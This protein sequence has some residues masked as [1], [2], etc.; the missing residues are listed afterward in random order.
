MAK[1]YVFPGQGSQ[2]AGMGGGLFKEFPQQTAAASAILGYAIEELCGPD[3][4]QELN[5]TEFTQPAL[6]VVNALSYLR[7]THSTSAPPNFVAG[8][9]LGEYNALFAAGVFDFNTGVRLVQKR[10][11]LMSRA[12][13]GAMAAVLGMTAPEVEKT[14]RD[15]GLEEIDIANLNAPQ[16]VVISGPVDRVLAAGTMFERAG[17]RMF[18]P[19][20]VSGSFHS[21]YMAAAQEEFEKYLSGF[22]FAPPQIPVISNVHARPYESDEVRQNLAHQITRPVRWVET[23][24]FLL[25]Q[26]NPEFEEIGPGT[27]LAGLI[28][29]IKARHAPGAAPS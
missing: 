24:E 9:S 5:R 6:F 21:R 20:K 23:I 1:I 17:A 7:K 25:R 15:N 22:A 13:G 11:A 28:R 4:R 8:H 18:I 27:V 2:K 26:P 10:G 19:L 29:Q 12:S 14:L 3:P 16:Q